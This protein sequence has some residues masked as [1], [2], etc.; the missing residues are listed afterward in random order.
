LL[1]GVADYDKAK[2]WLFELIK[3]GNIQQRFYEENN[4]MGLS[5]KR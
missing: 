3:S 1:I 4:F 2:E 5:I